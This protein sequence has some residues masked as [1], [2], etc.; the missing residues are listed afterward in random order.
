M[1]REANVARR[2]QRVTGL[3]PES[4]WQHDDVAG[5]RCIDHLVVRG[6]HRPQLGGGQLVSFGRLRAAQPESRHSL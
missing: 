2:V 4:A 5:R 6:V 1:D 3:Q